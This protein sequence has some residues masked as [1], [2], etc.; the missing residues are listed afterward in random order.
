M[1][2]R[3]N[4]KRRK[5]FEACGAFSRHHHQLAG[6]PLP[7]CWATMDTTRGAF[8]NPASNTPAALPK[9]TQAACKI[10]QY[11]RVVKESPA[12]PGNSGHVASNKGLYIA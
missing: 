5:P 8:P 2:R 10:V 3:S 1:R 7:A 11:R 9:A 6:S 4:E 12:F